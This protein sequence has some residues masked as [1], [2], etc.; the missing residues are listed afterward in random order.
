LSNSRKN[1]ERK[2]MV[3]KSMDFAQGS[4]KSRLIKDLLDSS[5]K[6]GSFDKRI[7]RWEPKSSRKKNAE[8]N[9]SISRTSNQKEINP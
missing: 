9:L 8:I 1:I 6:A 3:N 2:D 7:L 4:L 5:K